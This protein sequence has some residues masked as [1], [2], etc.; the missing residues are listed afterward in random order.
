M[1]RM[2]STRRWSQSPRLTASDVVCF[3]IVTGIIAGI[4]LALC[5]LVTLV[6]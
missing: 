5:V 2:E 4:I 6:A 3:A 1:K